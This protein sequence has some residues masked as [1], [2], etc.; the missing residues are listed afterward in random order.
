[1]FLGAVA[2]SL[3]SVSASD[4][5]AKTGNSAVTFTKDVAPILY[6]KCA[7]CHHAGEAAPFSVLSYKDVRPWARSIKEKVVSRQMPPWHADPHFGQWANDR[8]LSDQE[9]QR[10]SAWVDQGAKEG[11]AADLPAPPAFPD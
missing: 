5:D 10:I 4:K 1:M 6:A 11:D 9:I 3:S 7:D 8:R 2:A